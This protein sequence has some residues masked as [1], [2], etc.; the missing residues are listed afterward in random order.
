MIS[1]KQ[2]LSD[3]TNKMTRK[4]V[5]EGIRPYGLPLAEIL[6]NVRKDYVC[7][8]D[9]DEEQI[10]KASEELDAIVLKGKITQGKDLDENLGEFDVFV[11]ANNDDGKNL[12]SCLYVK[13][14]CKVGKV[15]SI[16]Q[17]EEDE[18][19]FVNHEIRPVSPEKAASK[20]LLRYMDGDPRLTDIITMSGQNELF[21]FEI[22]TQDELGKDKVSLVDKKI[23][24]IDLD[25]YNIVCVYREK[26]DK[27]IRAKPDYVLNAGDI[28]QLSIDPKDHKR[29]QKK[30]V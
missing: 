3:L 5:I 21:I 25:D 11:A 18:G 22:K 24:S 10:K 20:I 1:L 29:L 8:V 12:L 16:V 27:M 19:T 2:R 4:I 7:L 14:H 6:V 15:L 28:L 26:D 9:E 23:S 30:Y 17:N 13:E